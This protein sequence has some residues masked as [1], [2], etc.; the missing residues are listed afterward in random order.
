M[1]TRSLLKQNAKIALGGR[2]WR[3]FLVCLV[4]SLL[5]AGS[6]SSGAYASGRASADRVS[7]YANRDV[8]TGNG[9]SNI[10][11]ETL[12]T[13]RELLA[14]FGLALIVILLIAFVIALCFAAFLG[15]PLSVGRAR[16]MMESRQGDAPFA[17]LFSTFHA[18]YMNVVKVTL[19]TQLKIMAGSLIIVPGIL[20]SYEY[21]MVPYLLAENPYMTTNRAMELSRDMM[22]GEKWNTFVLE[23]SFIGW[24][25]LAGITFGI[26]YY[27][28][29]PYYEGTFAELYAALRS[30]AFAAGFTNEQELGGF[31]RY[32]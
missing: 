25:V 11:G 12:S 19:L 29:D 18:P 32:E 5:G 20:W 14:I 24:F 22:Y 2:Y 16:Y 4:A 23:L 1:W 30:K 13:Y 15:G 26:G 21:K 17:T 7:D 9:S 6:I 28:L 27:F 3:T 31:M 8:W 10:Y